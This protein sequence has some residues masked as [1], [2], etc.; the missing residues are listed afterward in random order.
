MAY[1][2]VVDHDA[3]Y[4]RYHAVYYRTHLEQ[5]KAY[6]AT[7]YLKNRSAMLEKAKRQYRRTKLRVLYETTSA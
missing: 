2:N 6:L 7:Y 4:A 5:R 1:K 3:Y